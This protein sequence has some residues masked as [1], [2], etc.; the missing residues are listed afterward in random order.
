VALQ[1]WYDPA[2]GL[3]Q[4][5]G[6]WNC[7]NALTTLVRYIKLTGDES[8]AA[9]IATTFPRPLRCPIYPFCPPPPSPPVES[10]CPRV[11]SYVLCAPPT[12]VI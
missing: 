9:V 5:T 10:V 1:R 8:N 6:W 11:R 4:G 2:T 3:W 12:P 7:A